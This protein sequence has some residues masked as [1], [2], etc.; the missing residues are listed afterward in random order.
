MARSAARVDMAISNN[1]TWEDA[2][3]FGVDG[4]TSWS[5]TGQ[6][7]LM[8]VKGTRDDPTPLLTMTNGGGEIVIDDYTQRVL[9]F[10]VDY[11]VFSPV[12][13][14]TVDCAPY[15]YDLVMVDNSDGTRV[16]LMGGTVTVE[17]GVSLP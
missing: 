15:V 13:P 9:H 2:F 4:D 1:A 11:T 10:N 14:V 6:S 7:F 3:K 17:Q 5:F 12:L 8:E 16:V